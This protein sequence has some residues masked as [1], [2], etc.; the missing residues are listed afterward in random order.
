IAHASVGRAI[1]VNL[2]HN[3]VDQRLAIAHSYA[4]AV[5]EPMGTIRVCTKANANELIERRAAACAAAFLL[6][7]SG[8]VDTVRGLGKGQPSRQVQWIFDAATERSVPAGSLSRCC[9]P[10][11]T[12][13]TS[14]LAGLLDGNRGSSIGTARNVRDLVK[15]RGTVPIQEPRLTKVLGRCAADVASRCTESSHG[16][17]TDK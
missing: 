9:A 13:D 3:A 14:P 6:P 17:A 5:C 7:A 2:A 15:R 10:A 4:H 16:I 11:V 8:V 1:V 12:G